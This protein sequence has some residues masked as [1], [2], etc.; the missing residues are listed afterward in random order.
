M[1]NHLQPLPMRSS[2]SGWYP[3]GTVCCNS[4]E[5]RHDVACESRRQGRSEARSRPNGQREIL[6]INDWFFG[7]E[8]VSTCFNDAE[9]Y[10]DLGLSFGRPQEAREATET[11]TAKWILHCPNVFQVPELQTCRGLFGSRPFETFRNFE[12]QLLSVASKLWS[13]C[14]HSSTQEGGFFGRAGHHSCGDGG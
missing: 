10:A 3:P 6:K 8:I 12:F 13:S 5:A 1:F 4:V 7:A 9:R 14:G 11:Q 2:Y